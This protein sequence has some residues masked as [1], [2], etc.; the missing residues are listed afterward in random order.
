MVL[1]GLLIGRSRNEVCISPRSMSKDMLNTHK[2]SS[3]CSGFGILYPCWSKFA[4]FLPSIRGYGEPPSKKK[5]KK[6]KWTLCNT[7]CKRLAMAIDFL[8]YNSCTRRPICT[9]GVVIERVKSFQLLGVYISEDLT[10]GDHCDY[11]VKESQS[12]PLCT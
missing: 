1:Q 11:I 8:D 2:S 12:P 3:T 6:W 7:E 9:G 4:I 5:K 10:W